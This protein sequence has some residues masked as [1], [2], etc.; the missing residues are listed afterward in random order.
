MNILKRIWCRICSH[1]Y[2]DFTSYVSLF[3]YPGSMVKY[4]ESLCYRC[5]HTLS[6]EAEVISGDEKLNK[7]IGRCSE[8]QV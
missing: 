2:V 4:K 6:H 7:L 8:L 1:S 3:N 5:G